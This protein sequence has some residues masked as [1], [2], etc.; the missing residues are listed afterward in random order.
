MSLEELLRPRVKVVGHYPGMILEIGDVLA[1][2]DGVYKPQY[3]NETTY[4]GIAP[5][6][7]EAEAKL[8]TAIFQEM[9][10]YKDRGMFDMPNFVKLVI[11][12]SLWS[13][14]SGAVCHARWGEYDDALKC[15]IHLGL[16]AYLKLDSVY[17]Y[18]AADSLNILPNQ[19]Y[20]IAPASTSEYQDYISKAK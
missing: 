20:R 18:T 17:L 19:L 2:Y 15:F 16:N 7:N 8:C 10:W 1:L 12:N 14:P 5:R 3:G 11:P 6:I 4:K 13:I 9:P